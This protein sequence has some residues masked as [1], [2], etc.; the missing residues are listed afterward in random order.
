M[1]FII[2]LNFS[3]VNKT[4]IGSFIFVMSG[5]VFSKITEIRAT[6]YIL[7]S[8]CLILLTYY[9]YLLLFCCLETHK[10][11]KECVELQE[12]WVEHISKDGFDTVTL[13][14][15]LN[16]LNEK[17]KKLIEFSNT[18][19]YTRQADKIY[20]VIGG[21][22]SFLTLYFLGKYPGTLFFKWIA[23]LEVVTISKRYVYYKSLG[24]HYFLVDFC[25]FWNLM[26]LTFKWF[27]F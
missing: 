6:A 9:M 26:I 1:S 7:N 25:Y 11:Y 8:V 12:K 15:I 19:R 2:K 4:R 17:K 13:K 5:I 14:S 22:L 20:Y 24:W 18:S 3:Y 16:K 27:V 21:L 10:I 23:I